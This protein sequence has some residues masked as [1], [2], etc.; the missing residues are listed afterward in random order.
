[1]VAGEQKWPP[2][3]ADRVEEGVAATCPV[4]CMAH[5]SPG[6]YFPIASQGYFGLGLADEDLLRLQATGPSEVAE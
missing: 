6:A 4:N 2:F 1:M 3:E 5:P